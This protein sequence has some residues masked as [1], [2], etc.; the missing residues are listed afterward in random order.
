[1]T[2][3]PKNEPAGGPPR[4]WWGLGLWGLLGAAASLAAALTVAG[5]LDGYVPALFVAPP[6]RVQFGVC[7]ALAAVVYAIG[8]RPRGAAACAVFALVNVAVVAPLYV[9]PQPLRNEG[10]AVRCLVV[11]VLASNRHRQPLLRLIE[12]ERPDVIA[13]SEVTPALWETLAPLRESEYPYH[14][15]ETRRSPFGIALL[16]R[17]P[18]EYAQVRFM[19]AQA[20]PW[21]RARVTTPGGSF[22]VVVAHPAAPLTRAHALLSIAELEQIA[23]ELGPRDGPRVL[24]GDLNATPWSARFRA[25]LAATELRDSARGFGVQATFP[26]RYPLMRIPLDHAL[27]S[28]EVE[29]LDRRLGPRIGADHLP[30]IVDLRLPR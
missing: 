21:I 8:R 2:S 26:V 7:L 11:N 18:L 20:H 25:L 16:S 22:E 1:M 28:E 29:V 14:R 10:P 4:R 30:L 3:A 19:G 13:L 27:V 6:F 23:A 9:A 24:L 17:L 5:F 15:S 12:R